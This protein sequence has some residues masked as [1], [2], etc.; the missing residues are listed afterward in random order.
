MLWRGRMTRVI[1]GMANPGQSDADRQ[2][3]Y[4]NPSY[5][6]PPVDILASPRPTFDVNC[7]SGSWWLCS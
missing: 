1:V 2:S 4:N 5:P 6:E 7:S 3:E